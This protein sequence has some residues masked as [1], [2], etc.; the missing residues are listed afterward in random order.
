MKS[1]VIGDVHTKVDLVEKILSKIEKNYKEIIILGDFFDSFAGNIES[2]EKTAQWLRESLN[3]PN[4]IHLYG[5]HDFHY[6]FYKNRLITGSGY[7]RNKAD[8]INKIL[9]KENWNKLKFFYV[10]QNFVFSHA[11]FH[12]GLLHLING[13]DS[14]YIYSKIMKEYFEINNSYVGSY[15]GIGKARGGNLTKGGILWQDW[16]LEFEPISDVN[17]ILG[18]TPGKFVRY[19]NYN[20]SINVCVDTNLKYI[21]SIDNGKLKEIKIY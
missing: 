12:Q 8:A 3:K 19:R 18:H 21:L 13:F 7:S 2:N 10:S 14:D 9:T 15:F 6:R 17:Q 20:D 16:D 4:R 5:N 1:L 11:G